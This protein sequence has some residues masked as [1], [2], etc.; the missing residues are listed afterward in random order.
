M[1]KIGF[2]LVN[3]SSFKVL[4]KFL[5]FKLFIHASNAPTPGKINLSNFDIRSGLSIISQSNPKYSIALLTEVKF[6]N[7]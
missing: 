4:T 6:H 2:F 1:P 7:L 3:T 5:V